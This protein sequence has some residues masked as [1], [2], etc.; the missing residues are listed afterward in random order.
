MVSSRSSNCASKV[1]VRVKLSSTLTNQ[2]QKLCGLLSQMVGQF[3][4]EGNQMSDV[5][6]QQM[7]LQHN[8]LTQLITIHVEMMGE[9]K[10]MS[11]YCTDLWCCLFQI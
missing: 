7:A 1:N 4:V 6:V 9:S 2:R 11:F 3:L 10:R 8:V 5:N